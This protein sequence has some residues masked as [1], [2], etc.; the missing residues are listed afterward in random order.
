MYAWHAPAIAQEAAANEDTARPLFYP[1]LPDLPRIQYLASYSF[2]SDVEEKE[3]KKSGWLSDFVLGEESEEV[4]EGPNKP[5]GVALNKGQIHVVDTRGSGYAIFDLRNKDYRFKVGS[6]PSS[7]PKPINIEID[8]EGRKY[9]ADTVRNQVVVFDEEDEFL[10]AFGRR[11]QFRPTDALVDGDKLFVVDI[12]EHRIVVLDKNTG[13]ELG[14]FGSVGSDE[15]K[16]FQPTNIAMGPN[17]HL[18]V[19]DT[20]NFRVQEFTQDGEVVKSYGAGVGRA[21][22]NFARPKGVAV[23]REG[24]VYV[25]DAAY[26]RVQV[27]DDEGRLLMFFGEPSGTHISGLDLPT[28]IAIDYE[29]VPY[30]QKHADPDFEVE[31][32]IAVV[33][34][35][36]MSKVNV[37][38]FGRHKSMSYDEE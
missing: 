24:R 36:G 1:P 22:G 31:F 2:A 15:N 25:V 18:Y 20:G 8:D 9:V 33:N 23:D 10:Q 21:P 11:G 19:S 4:V 27:F 34:Q 26:E 38:G 16:L 14:S 5:Y 29:S 32:I 3:E 30:F 28:D 7:M 37:F 6:G 17:G 12:Q 13:E 35:F